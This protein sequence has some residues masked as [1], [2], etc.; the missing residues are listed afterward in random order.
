MRD[1]GSSKVKLSCLE[2]G[3][4]FV[5]WRSHYKRG[6]TRFCSTS[7]GTR[8]RNLRN[9]PAQKPEVR[10]AISENHADVS[11]ANNPMYGRRGELAPAWIDGRSQF[12]GDSY[13]KAALANLEHKCDICGLEPEDLSRLHAHHKDFDHGNDD[14]KNLQILCIPCHN[15]VVHARERDDAGRFLPESTE[16]Q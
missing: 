12:A 11:G 6:N 15:N 14:L 16:A 4:E 7:C 9:N 10:R 3:A 13:R 2:C 5:V 1:T 8:Y